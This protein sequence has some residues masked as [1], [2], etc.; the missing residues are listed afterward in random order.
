MKI[1]GS[2]KVFEDNTS[3]KKF[4]S[5]SKAFQDGRTL[6]KGRKQQKSHWS[7]C[8]NKIH[9]TNITLRVREIVRTKNV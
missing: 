9:L 4:I 1:N 6:K 3:W 8:W 2:Y 5:S 7:Y